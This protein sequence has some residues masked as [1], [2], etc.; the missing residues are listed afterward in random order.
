[1]DASII[2]PTYNRERLLN[3]CLECLLDQDYP[4]RK[5]E[6]IIVDDASTDQTE[7]VVRDKRNRGNLIL[8]QQ[9]KR[10][11]PAAARN[12][13][14]PEAEGRIVIFIDS[15]VLVPPG[16]VRRHVE[17]H[18]NH[19]PIILDGPA[20]NIT[21]EKDVSK[22]PF[23]SPLTR[24]LALL[25]RGGATFITANVSVLRQ[26]LRRSGGFDEAFTWAWEDIELGRRL[27]NAGLR[28]VKDPGAYAFHCKIGRSSLVERAALRKERAEFGALYFRKHPSP[29]AARAVRMR[30]LT[31]DR[32]LE[33]IG[34]AE[35]YFSPS[36]L[37]G[38]D[39]QPW[40]PPFFK[41]LCLIH[42]H[43]QGL[44]QGLKPSR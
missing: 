23:G 36:A 18:G 28:R 13:A 26:E 14:I 9:D 32:I 10:L 43:A 1:M 15:D 41:K 22:P 8:L 38:M 33:K 12:R 24:L 40:W 34:W 16:F 20:I 44:K 21:R 17:A 19:A 3:R 37:A 31:I 2:I 4:A 29:G 39:K 42:A 35:K 25:D 27:M 6:I 7:K 5:F 11:G 30:Y